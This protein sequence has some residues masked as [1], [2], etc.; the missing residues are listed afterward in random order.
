MKVIS[1]LI[2]NKYFQDFDTWPFNRV[3][4]PNRGSTVF[5]NIS[6][7]RHS[8]ELSRN[9]NLDNVRFNTGVK[10]FSIIYF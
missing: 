2:Y 9:L 4:P 8:N 3:W 10:F 6:T 7:Y 1:L 5:M